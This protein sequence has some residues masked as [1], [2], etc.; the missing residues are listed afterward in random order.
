MAKKLKTYLTSLGFFDQAVA[1]PSMK[2]ALD[3]WGSK[4]N[5]FHQGFATEV[6]DPAI[7]EATMARPGVVLKRPIGSNG[8]F[9]ETAELPEELPVEGGRR[10]QAK[11]ASKRRPPRREPDEKAA[12]KAAQ[13]FER[14]EAKRAKQRRKEEAAREKER[15]RRQEAVAKAQAAFDAAE[16]GHAKR[17]RVIEGDREALEK[18]SQAEDDRWHKEKSKLE[19]ALRRARS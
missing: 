2:A 1:A 6:D 19:A 13:A 12:R 3:A 7:V 5:L 14:E 18:R 16:R 9:K 15:E 17:A 11:P 4:S 10:K 8:A